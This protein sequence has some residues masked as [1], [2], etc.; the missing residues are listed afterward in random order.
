MALRTTT[1]GSYP[2]PDYLRIP[3]FIPK[4]PDPTRRHGEYLARRTEA[5]AALLRRATIENVRHQVDAGIDIPTDG[6]TPR[7]HYVHYHLRHLAGVDFEALSERVIRHGPH[8]GRGWVG[9]SV[10]GSVASRLLG[11]GDVT[12]ESDL[13]GERGNDGVGEDVQ[14]GVSGDLL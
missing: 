8:R 5:D 14:S 3:P 9:W 11:E 1:I 7:S 6:E 12:F 13:A 2:K 10:P 4:H